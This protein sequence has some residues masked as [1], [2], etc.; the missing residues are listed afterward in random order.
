MSAFIHPSAF[1]DPGAEI[2]ADVTIGPCALIEKNVIIGDGC[3]IDAFASI[4]EYTK[5]GRGNVV[6]SYAM[7]G[8][9]PQDLKFRG[10]ESRLE[11]G[12][13]NVIREFATL[14]RGTEGGGGL[15]RIGNEN[16][17]MSYT[18]VAHDCKIG[19]KVIMSNNA[20]LA[21]HVTVGDGAIIGGLSPVHQFCRIG[22]HAFVGG[23]SGIRLDVP[24]YL[25]AAHPQARLI[26]PNV[27]GLRR[28]G[29]SS[30]TVAAL[31]AAFRLIF[32][33]GTVRADALAMA[34][35][36]YAHL[37][38]VSEMV[39]FIKESPRG[40]LAAGKEDDE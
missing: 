7:V 29:A 26:G 9:V 16:L 3:R 14:H 8:N 20:T 1:V 27:V 11:I 6:H 22:N 31:R 5:M 23:L 37:P 28:M 39:K 19:D 34:E 38:E 15:T 32:L 33:S 2:G 13:N 40:V 12:D 18:H 30:S 35:A 21:G 17:L 4:K 36:E 10:E 25:M 24:P